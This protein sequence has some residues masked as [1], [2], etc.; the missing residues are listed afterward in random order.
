MTI[1]S[2]VR[3]GRCD[4]RRSSPGRCRA[5]PETSHAG[6]SAEAVGVAAHSLTVTTVDE[7]IERSPVPATSRRSLERMLA[8]NPPAAAALA[9][10][11]L[12]AAAFAAVTGAS[13]PLSRLLE[14]DPEA[15]AVLARLDHRP[16][17]AAGSPEQLARCKRL[18]QL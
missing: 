2:S 12:L 8:A 17:I 3:S 6:A 15:L 1:R 16:E 9:A 14:T 4:R 7:A 10:D 11:P 13:R 18:E 5:S